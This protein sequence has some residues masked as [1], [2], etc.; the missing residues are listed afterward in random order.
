MTT[1]SF[2]IARLAAA[3]LVAAWGAPAQDLGVKAPAQTRAVRLVHVTVHPVSGPV[4]ENG[5]VRFEGGKITA[6]GPMT[7]GEDS[8]PSDEIID[9][10][11]RHVYPGLVAPQTQLGLTEFG[12][13]RVSQDFDELGVMTPEV[14]AVSAVNPDSTL[15]PVTRRNGILTAGV[16]PASGLISG[17][18]SVIRMDGWTADDLTVKGV[19]GL[20]IVW[21]TVR[22]ARG[23]RGF[24]GDAPA[25][26][27]G[28]GAADSPGAK[29]LTLLEDTFRAAEAY[30]GR[31]LEN[32][33]APVDL[34][35]EAM[36]P[37]VHPLKPA[38]GAKVEPVLPIFVAAEERDQM[39][40]AVTF[41]AKHGLKLVITGG[42]DAIQIAPLLK[43]H[44]VAVILSGTFKFPRR[45]DAPYDDAFTLPRRLNE[46]GVSWCLAGGDETPHERNLPYAA[47]LAVAHGLSPEAALRA[48]TLSAAEILGVGDTL[49][50]IEAG[51][52]ATMFV[53]D[54]DPLLVATKI[55]R[56][57][58][59]GRAID[60]SNKQTK[61]A[62]KYREKYRQRG[63]I[64]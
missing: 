7:N 56:A 32:P 10:P 37:F 47:G 19:A 24:F 30:A 25:P 54:G 44:G 57:W 42:R 50:S 16:F 26:A 27:A 3:V 49:G 38:D 58:I 35:L 9:A 4:V 36:R 43:R 11:G 55:E 22:A 5:F 60:L 20:V 15:L 1:S 8:V 13:I 61:L 59:D 40:S 31:R 23:G 6:T 64:K 46:T 34:R 21:P 33:N 14:R 48:I 52:Q 51:K 28:D 12:S 63:L 41:S 2:S 17:R 45:A 29:D 62:E 53:S 18:A 39:V